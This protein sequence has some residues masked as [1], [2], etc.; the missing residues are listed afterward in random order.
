MGKEISTGKRD[1]SHTPGPW[2]ANKRGI[3]TMPDGLV[4]AFCAC[5]AD[6]R[7]MAAA[8]V[9]LEAADEA[10]IALLSIPHDSALRVRT[11][12]PRGR[13]CNFI[14]QATGRAPEDVQN[15]YEERAAIA[16]GDKS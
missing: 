13:L 14:A 9:G 8:P 11:D 7:L 12:R 1:V 6:A 15:E 16:A 3:I 5:S 2:V 4:L 10:Y